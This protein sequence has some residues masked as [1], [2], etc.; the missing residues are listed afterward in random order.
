M[1][2]E[3]RWRL[4]NGFQKDIYFACFSTL[5]FSQQ[6]NIPQRIIYSQRKDGA[7]HFEAKCISYLSLHPKPKIVGYPQEIFGNVAQNPE[8]SALSSSSRWKAA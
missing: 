7:A 8:L 2:I 6:P 4:S 3:N 5:P 1:H